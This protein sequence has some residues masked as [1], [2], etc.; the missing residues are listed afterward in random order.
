[1]K[2]RLRWLETIVGAWKPAQPPEQLLSFLSPE[3]LVTMVLKDPAARDA[4]S[5]TFPHLTLQQVAEIAVGEDTVRR[6]L[7]KIDAEAASRRVPAGDA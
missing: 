2:A 7:A 4:P 3:E 5:E 1:M 6:A